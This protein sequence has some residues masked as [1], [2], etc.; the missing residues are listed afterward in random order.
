VVAFR[1]SEW[2]VFLH[3]L[4]APRSDALVMVATFLLTLLVDLT[5][6]IG[7]GMVLAAFLFMKR[8]AEVTNITIVS[9]E[10]QEAGEAAAET[11]GAIYRREVPPGVE[12]YE[13]NGPFFF[14]A[15]EKFKQTL[16]DVSRRPQVLI[17]RMRNV[18]AIDSTAM[19]AL[20]D[21]IR[22]TRAEGTRILLSDV[23]SQP[24]IAL[25]RSGLLDEIGEENLFGDVDA[26][27]EAARQRLQ[28]AS[29]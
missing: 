21:L 7:V 19:H 14:G 10:F 29:A 26:A 12:V 23:H 28:P 17:I 13:I 18:P 27:L 25:G 22:R 1:L 16:G 5:V 4:H 20:K 9:R 15:A 24:L 6:G 11:G 2:H 8:M 3:E